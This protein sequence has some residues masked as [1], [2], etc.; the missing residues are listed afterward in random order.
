MVVVTTSGCVVSMA[1][2]D[3]PTQAVA[4]T[5]NVTTR[6]ANRDA[7]FNYSSSSPERLTVRS[8]PRQPLAVRS[9]TCKPAN[10]PM[11]RCKKQT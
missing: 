11:K 8:R 9:L 6:P 3:D 10:A 2:G 1:P 4:T 5:A 7:D